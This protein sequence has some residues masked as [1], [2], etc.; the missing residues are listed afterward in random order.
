MNED[1]E[2]KSLV[3]KPYLKNKN[4]LKFGGSVDSKGIIREALSRDEFREMKSRCPVDKSNILFAED[5]RDC[6][7]YDT[8]ESVIDEI[9]EFLDDQDVLTPKG[10]ELAR[11]FWERYIHEED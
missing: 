1:D 6:I 4:K 10:K 2:I 11:V 9:L 8:N 5:L 7:G 3:G